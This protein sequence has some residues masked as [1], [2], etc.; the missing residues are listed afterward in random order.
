M[1][2]DLQRRAFTDP[3]PVALQGSLRIPGKRAEYLVRQSQANIRQSREL[4]SLSQ[5]LIR[6]ARSKTE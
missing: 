1:A 2:V 4:I 5:E 6:N 3:R